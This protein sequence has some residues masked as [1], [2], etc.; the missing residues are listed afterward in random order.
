MKIVPARDAVRSIADG[1]RV[2]LPHGCVEPTAFYEAL[3]AERERFRTLRLFSG[4]QFGTYPFLQAGLG[5]NFTYATWQ[6][7]AKI[8]HLFRGA[9]AQLL[10]LRF[11]DV[12]RV[13]NKD[14]PLP[15]DVVVV[16][17]SPPQDSHVNLGISVSLYRDLIAHARLVIA[18]INERVPITHGNT[19][20]RADDIDL[21]IESDA[22]LGHYPAPRRTSRDE[23]IVERV[24][25][26]IPPGAAV[27][28]GVGAVPDAVL[29]R[30]HEID[31]ARIHSGM[32]T[33]GLI[34][35]VTKSRGTPSV[36]TG[37]VAGSA[38]LYDFVAATPT[39]ELHPSRITHDLGS[40]CKL[41]R[42]VSINSAVEVDVHGQVNGETVDGLQIS[43]VGGS[44]DFVEGAAA[45]AGGMAILALP[46]T[47]E[48]GKRSKIVRRLGV[49][50]P[51]T[52]PRYCTDYVVTE[53]GVARLKGKTLEE[54][55][56]ALRDLAHPDFR[57]HLSSAE[58][59]AG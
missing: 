51:V 28:F 50:T 17:T 57:A 7:S 11:R 56:E 54:R 30:L 45:S 12:V 32:L 42:F 55:E 35:F 58:A 21:A 38:A 13:V 52:I 40:I 20:V 16:Q 26:L 29:S 24:L 3:Q 44:L 19:R 14:G 49:Q 34:D 23:R 31:G 47:T 46:S 59:S 25:S 41:P 22:E 39:I 9:R 1:A 53:F 48:N 8:R 2:I 5:N 10:P 36:V 43:G 6:A 37:E 15:P 4:L 18:E 33:D 27:Q